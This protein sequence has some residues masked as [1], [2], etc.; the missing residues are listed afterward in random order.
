MIVRKGTTFLTTL[1]INI[2][3]E[4][5][6]RWRRVCN[7]KESVI[8]GWAFTCRPKC[9]SRRSRACGRWVAQ[10]RENHSKPLLRH[11]IHQTPHKPYKDNYQKPSK[12]LY[13]TLVSPNAVYSLCIHCNCI[14][15]RILS[16]FRPIIQY[17]PVGSLVMKSILWTP[18]N[19]RTW[20]SLKNDV[21]TP[22][23]NK[24]FNSKLIIWIMHL[25]YLLHIWIV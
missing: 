24:A 6:F 7:E 9:G 5:F 8:K 3:A 18:T 10:C 14:Y 25:W 23:R 20:F 13:L 15:P 19:Q 12:Q 2:R 16:N 4:K 21:K 17:F 22:Q 11:C 1:C